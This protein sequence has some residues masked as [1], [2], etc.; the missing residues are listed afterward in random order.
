MSCFFLKSDP[1]NRTN[2]FF[3]ILLSI[4]KNLFF[5]NFIIFANSTGII[6]SKGF[7]IIAPVIISIQVNFLY[8]TFGL[9]PAAK[10]FKTLNFI[11]FLFEVYFESDDLIA[12][13]SKAELLA[14]G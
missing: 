9:S 1:Q 10:T 13:P 7:G 11:S 5:F 6:V 4:D 8:F 12:N 2:W 3:F 14:A